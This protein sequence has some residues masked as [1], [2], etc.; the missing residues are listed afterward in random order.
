MGSRTETVVQVRE[1]F[2]KMAEKKEIFIFREKWLCPLTTRKP[3]IIA[4]PLTYPPRC[5]SCADPGQT[6]LSPDTGFGSRGSPDH[7]PLR[8]RT[9]N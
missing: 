7:T 2:F 3:E 5:R 9:V 4:D 1:L 8:Q 6:S